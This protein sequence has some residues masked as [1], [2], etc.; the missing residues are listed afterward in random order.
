MHT[1]TKLI[2]TYSSNIP[3]NCHI[4]KGRLETDGILCFIFDEHM[5]WVDPF[6]AVAIGGVKLKVPFDQYEQS[7]TI[8]KSMSKGLLVDESGEHK[9]SD[10]FENEIKRQ[11]KI[12]SIKNKIRNDVA[13][14]E[15]PSAIDNN[16]LDEKEIENILSDEREFQ[17]I[18]NR[19]L[20]FTWKQ[21]FYELFDFDRSVFK[22]FRIRPTD[23]Y[24]EKELVDN[25]INTKESQ[26]IKYCPKCNTGN[27]AF[28]W[29]IDVKWNILYLIL[30]ILII[31]P[32]FPLRKKHHCFNC[33]HN[34][35]KST[36][37]QGQ[38][39]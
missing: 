22:Y 18:T 36:N 35:R 34:F 4:L 33:G 16:L 32:F 20:N 5:I 13:L 38:Q 25:Y 10:V 19:R 1:N 28:G 27:T 7:Q 3:I 29:A 21:F 31:T 37:N 2:T 26:H 8:I 23:Y 12:L 17:E 39:T 11:N 9:I 14:L 30:S 15:N 6:K 24:L